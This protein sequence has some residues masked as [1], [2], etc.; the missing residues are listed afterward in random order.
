MTYSLKSE[1]AF[2]GRV[3]LNIGLASTTIRNDAR[4]LK[5]FYRPKIEDL[6]RLT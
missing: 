4:N 3:I 6:L 2:Y 1:D 5:E